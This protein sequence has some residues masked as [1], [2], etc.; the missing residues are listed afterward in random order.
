MGMSLGGSFI[1]NFDLLYFSRIK[2]LKAGALL[3]LAPRTMS[4]SFQCVP[5]LNWKVKG[6]HGSNTQQ[7][8]I[9]Y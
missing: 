5:A 3:S 8:G 2:V 4:M 7:D 6:F 1:A 9:F